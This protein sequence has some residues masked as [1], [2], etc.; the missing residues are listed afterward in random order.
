MVALSSF[1]PAGLSWKTA[2]VKEEKYACEV[3]NVYDM[4]DCFTGPS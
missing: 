2:N 1:L 4:C 3:S